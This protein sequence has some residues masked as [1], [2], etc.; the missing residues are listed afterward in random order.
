MGGSNWPTTSVRLV[1]ALRRPEDHVAWERFSTEYGPALLEFCER[2]GLQRADAE[3]LVQTVFVGVHRKI[4]VLEF[5]EDRG[6]FRSWLSTIALRAIW[7]LRYRK[8]GR[9]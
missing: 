7:K 2:R 6:R 5:S 1:A 8:N 4:G 9:H 3:D